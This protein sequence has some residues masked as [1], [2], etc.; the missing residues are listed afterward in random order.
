MTADLN[1]MSYEKRLKYGPKLIKESIKKAH[2]GSQDSKNPWAPLM[3]GGCPLLMLS[4]VFWLGP[5]HF[6]MHSDA[7]FRDFQYT[8]G[9]G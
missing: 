9:Y 6:Q 2:K 5:D 7:M 1:C 4:P 8:K 3:R